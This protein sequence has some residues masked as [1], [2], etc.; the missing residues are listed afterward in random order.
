LLYRGLI[1]QTPI[2]TVR[3][4]QR[5]QTITIVWMSVEAAISLFAAWRA[6]SPALLAFGGDSAIELLSA[7]AVLWRFRA[8]VPQERAERR[9]ARIAGVLLFA[10]AACIVIVSV[11]ALV[12]YGGCSES[13]T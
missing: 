12:G 13:P 7:V 3:R 11:M 5:V 6:K 9:A 1:P 8:N 10:L 4:V 2:D